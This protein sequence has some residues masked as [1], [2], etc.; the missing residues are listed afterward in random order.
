MS[1]TYPGHVPARWALPLLQALDTRSAG[2][3]LVELDEDDLGGL[4]LPAHAGETCHGDSLQLGDDAD[5]GSLRE[6]ADWLAR[7]AERYAAANPS[8]WGRITHAA[9]AAGPAAGTVAGAGA[10]ALS[11]IVVSAFSVGDR[12]KP[13]HAALVVVDG[14]HRAL[15]Y[16][17]AGH[18]RCPAY[19]PV[20]PPVPGGVGEA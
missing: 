17:L 14:L 8:C 13:A 12:V 4:W 20:P 16:W 15:A 19:L 3:Q 10:G 18:R 2:W 6:A 7:N 11:P 9:A 5:G 1:A